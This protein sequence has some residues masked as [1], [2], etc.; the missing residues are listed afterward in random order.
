[1]KNT[2][3]LTK[4]LLAVRLSYGDMFIDNK[5]GYIVMLIQ[6]TRNRFVLDHGSAIGKYTVRPAYYAQEVLLKNYTLIGKAHEFLP[7]S[8]AA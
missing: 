1:M 3:I 5:T 2:N 6:C 8:N 7:E 4:K